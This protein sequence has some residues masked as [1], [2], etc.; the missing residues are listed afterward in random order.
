MF[1]CPGPIAAVVFPRA[2]EA[3]AVA[4]P[5]VEIFPFEST[6][7]LSPLP[8]VSKEAGEVSPI[9]MLP[10]LVMASFS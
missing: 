3:E 10:V 4:Y 1:K 8:T 6:W 7:N 2:R 5:V 9:P